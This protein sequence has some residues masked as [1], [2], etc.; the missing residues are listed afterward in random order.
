MRIA[1][2][3]K[4]CVGAGICVIEEPRIFRF[5]EGSK[6]AVVTSPEAPPPLE[7]KL[8][9]IARKCPNGAIIVKEDDGSYWQGEAS[10]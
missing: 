8:R 2:D 3:A 10:S 4:K 6:Q 1:I 5:R 9:Q 7:A